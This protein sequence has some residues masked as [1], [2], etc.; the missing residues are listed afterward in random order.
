MFFNKNLPAKRTLQLWHSCID[1]T[2]GICQAAMMILREKANQYFMENNHQLHV[3]LIYDDVHIRTQLCYCPEKDEFIGYP[4]YGKSSNNDTDEPPSLAKEALFYMVAGKDFKLAIGYELCNGLDAFDRAALTLR[5]IKELEATGVKVT[6]LTGDGLRGNKA[7]VVAL[8]ARFD[9]DQPY[10][11]SPTYPDQK[12][13]V[14]FDPPHM[15]KL[16]RKHFASKMIYHNDKLVDWGLL[17]ILVEKQSLNNFNL[18]NKLTS[19]HIDWHQKPMNVRLAAETI[20][21]S[22]ANTLDQLCKDGYE[23]FKDAATTSD[24]LRYFNNVFDILNFGEGKKSDDKYKI[25]LCNETA[26]KIFEFAEE[27]KQFVTQLEYHT[28]T[29]RRVPLWTSDV[30]MG[31]MGFY[32]NFIS[33]RGIYEDFVQNGPLDIF[34]PFQFSQ[35]HLETYFSLVRYRKYNLKY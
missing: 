21:N 12:I 4:T 16:A 32:Y 23:E 13:Y 14:I 3:G 33:L 18:C 7:A 30:G 29:N 26:D 28:K 34:Y 10:F 9:L 35:D 17:E 11:K 8:G 5:V 2:P 31:F 24:F 6:S 15:L 20:S 1:G 25:P 27:F 19:L 22:T